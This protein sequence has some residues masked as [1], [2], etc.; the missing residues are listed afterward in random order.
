MTE[1]FNRFSNPSARLQ[2]MIFTNLYVS[3]AAF[4]SSASTLVTHPLMASILHSVLLDNSTT[5]CT[6]GLTVL[7]K[8]LPIF[9]VHA[10][11][12]LVDFVPILFA[13]LARIA[14]WKQ[15]LL[16]HDIE[17]DGCA[18]ELDPDNHG[19]LQIRTELEWQRLETT[20]L[21]SS[22][23]TSLR[24]YFT[25]L[26]YLFPLNLF[27]FLRGPGYYLSNHNFRS[28]YTVDWDEVLDHTEIRNRIEVC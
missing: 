23:V 5:C 1:L 18:D 19:D 14:C 7:T 26:Y 3:N 13:I 6:I 27:K 20:F 10:P 22:P 28:P 4:E 24:P 9:A 12:N 25:F 17:T 8:L 21:Q 15:R 11:P 16:N 2:L